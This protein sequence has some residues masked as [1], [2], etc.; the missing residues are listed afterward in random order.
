MGTHLNYGLYSKCI[1]IH[2]KMEIFHFLLST[3]TVPAPGKC[4]PTRNK[5]LTGLQPEFIRTLPSKHMTFLMLLPMPTVHPLL[6]Y[7][8]PVLHTMNIVPTTRLQLT[9]TLCCHHVRFC[10]PPVTIPNNSTTLAALSEHQTPDTILTRP[11]KIRQYHMQAQVKL[12][13][14]QVKQNT[15]DT[16]SVFQ[17]KYRNPG[18]HAS[19]KNLLRPP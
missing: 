1:I 3:S 2:R 10:L 7:L 14:L 18:P 13:S 8:V 6:T 17:N 4:M 11:L 5:R 9:S 19:D 12:V 15:R 16:R